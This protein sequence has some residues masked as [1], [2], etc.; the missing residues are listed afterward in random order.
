MLNKQGKMA[1]S[2]QRSKKAPKV[3]PKE[4]EKVSRIS[5]E[6]I[7]AIS[8]DE[9]EAN[10]DSAEWDAEAVALRQ[11]IADGAFDHLLKKTKGSAEKEA[12]AASQDDSDQESEENEQVETLEADSEKEDEESDSDDEE[13]EEEARLRAVAANSGKALL[14]VTRELMARNNSLPFAEKSVVECQHDKRSYEK[15]D[16]LRVKR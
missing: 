1:K 13:K 14:A 15:C 7:D 12:D 10:E 9:D 5:L 4:E 11:A 6:E 16:E 2:K 3:A 8:S